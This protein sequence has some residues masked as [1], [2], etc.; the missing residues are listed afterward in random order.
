MMGLW[1]FS[2]GEKTWRNR[3]TVRHSLGAKIRIHDLSAR[4]YGLAF[5]LDNLF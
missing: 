3:I 4:Q 5:L 2:D 1:L